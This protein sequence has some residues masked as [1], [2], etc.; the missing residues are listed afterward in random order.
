LGLLPKMHLRQ[1][2][3]ANISLV[4]L[5]CATFCLSV[6]YGLLFVVDRKNQRL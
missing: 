6:V 1:S 4:L 3:Y 5:L 2:F